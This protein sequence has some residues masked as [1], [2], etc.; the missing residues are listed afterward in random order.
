MWNRTNGWLYGWPLSFTDKRQEEK[1]SP[2]AVVQTS[3]TLT[4]SSLWT[5]RLHPSNNTHQCNLWNILILKTCFDL[6]VSQWYK[7]SVKKERSH[8]T[9]TQKTRAD[10][11]GTSSEVS[12][13]AISE[14]GVVLSGLRVPLAVDHACIWRYAFILLFTPK[15]IP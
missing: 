9:S 11:T 5:L 8:Q 2:E 14:D 7:A 10:K 4:T 12:S 13:R 6:Y 3:S 15:T 1:R